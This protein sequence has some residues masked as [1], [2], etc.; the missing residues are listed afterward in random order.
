MCLLTFMPPKV[1]IEYTKA[2]VAAKSNPHGFGFAIHAENRII[3]DHDMDFQKLWE[4]W[5]IIRATEQGAAIFHFRIA[6]HGTN[7][8]DN[9]HPFNIGDDQKTVMAHNGMLPLRMPIDDNRSDTKLF[10]QYVM[11]SMG[12]IT[13]LDN[14]STFTK[15]ADW[16]IGS[17]LVFLTVDP[18]AEYDWYIVNEEYGHWAN[19]MWW[20]NKSYV[21][22]P[23]SPYVY[24]GASTYKPGM[25]SNLDMY[26]DDYSYARAGHREEEHENTAVELQEYLAD[27]VYED[28][29]HLDLIRIFTEFNGIDQIAT[30]TCYE[31]G[32]I[33]RV[34]PFEPSA[35]HCGA[36]KNCFACG[37]NQCGC[38]MD[39]EYG[40]SFLQYENSLEEK[41]LPL[42]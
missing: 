10:A 4:R 37:N 25:Y 31:C 20:S 42:W 39:F 15:L 1:N 6:T 17:K 24:T 21:H 36:C 22:Y 40:Q 19:D 28:S 32:Q 5:S 9:C 11:P 13:S 27:G 26:D 33:Y 14:T 12:G 18:L 23:I 30:V 38:W 7:D 35:T 8:V 2:C 29:Q 34:D 41:Q 3:K 16:A